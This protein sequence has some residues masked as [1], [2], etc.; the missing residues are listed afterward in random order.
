MAYASK[1]KLSD[2]SIVPL[3][4][5][6]FGVCLTASG[7]AQKDVTM[8]D[9]NVLVEGVTIHVYF[10]NAN[11]ASNPT[12][13][14]GS[15]EA[16]SVSGD[17]IAGGFAS[18][19]Y[20]NGTWIQNDVSVGGGGGSGVSSVNGHTGNVVLGASD[21]GALPDNTAI[22]TKT[23]D[24]TN[25]S[26]FITGESDPTV[27]SWAKQSTKPTYTASEVGALPDN[28][29]IPSK[30][31]DLTNDSGFITS[32]S[33]PTVPSWAKQANKPTYTASEVGALPD[34]T[35]IPTKTSDLTN[36]SGFITTET[37]PTVP[38]WAKQANKPTYTASEVGALPDNTPIPSKTSDLTNDSGFITLADLPIYNGGVI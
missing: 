20:Y 7:T 4:S 33:D 21:V 8:P 15:T 13:K 22:P 19:T 5:N 36:D 11:T 28:T 34:T 26:G 17:W 27:P 25:D 30:T 23:S 3:A 24:L 31:S 1:K 35:P 18:F 6:L 37:D 10:D 38:N 2:N 12:L 14:V 32:E 16:R 29:P 9:F